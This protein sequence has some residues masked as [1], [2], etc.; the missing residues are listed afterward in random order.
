MLIVAED[1]A[2]RQAPQKILIK[3]NLTEL[4]SRDGSPSV[5]LL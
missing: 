4:P 5:L 1:Q 2:E 3:L